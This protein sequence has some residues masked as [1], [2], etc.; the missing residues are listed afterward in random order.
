[1]SINTGQRP[2][3]GYRSGCD[4]FGE[5]LSCPGIVEMQAAGDGEFFFL[6]AQNLPQ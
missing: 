5:A 1:M 3:A 4:Q 6:R 2:A